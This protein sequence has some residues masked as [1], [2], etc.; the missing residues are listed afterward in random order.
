MGFGNAVLFATLVRRL[1]YP[2][3]ILIKEFQPAFGS[4]QGNKI[5]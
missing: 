4:N 1:D 2:G 3:T 5:K